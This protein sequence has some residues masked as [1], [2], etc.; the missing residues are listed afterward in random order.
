MFWYMSEQANTRYVSEHDWSSEWVILSILAH[1][2]HLAQS[3]FSPIFSAFMAYNCSWFLLTI[4][5]NCS[6]WRHKHGEKWPMLMTFFL[7]AIAAITGMT[8]F[9]NRSN[10]WK[11]SVSVGSSSQSSHLTE[12]I[13]WSAIIYKL[14]TE[15]LTN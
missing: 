4:K 5:K 12:C 7:T 1:R 13:Q 11:V 6:N 3:Y 10:S 14:Y 9:F 15:S 8:I 2:A